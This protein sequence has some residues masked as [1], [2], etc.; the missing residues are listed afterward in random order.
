MDFQQGRPLAYLSLHYAV[1]FFRLLEI[2]EEHLQLLLVYDH[3]TVLLQTDLL[4]I[5][6]AE[7]EMPNS[8]P[9]V[10]FSNVCF[11]HPKVT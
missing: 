6:Q 7:S 3:L 10:F 4:I 11:S 1:D 5:F 2:D 8:T 9:L